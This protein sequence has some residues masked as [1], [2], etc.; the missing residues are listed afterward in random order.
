M[1][2]VH[3]SMQ[4][5]EVTNFPLNGVLIEATTAMLTLPN[6]SQLQITLVYRPPSVPTSTLLTVMSSILTCSVSSSIPSI[7]LG[8]F[9]EDLITCPATQLLSL[10]SSH[11]FSQLVDCPTTDNGSLLDHVYCNRPCD[12]HTVQVLDAYYSDHDIVH[13]SIQM[14]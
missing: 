10:M 5:S 1:M 3:P 14:S 6:H 4:V 11:G 2:S 9:N 12:C 7:V 8:D 13:C